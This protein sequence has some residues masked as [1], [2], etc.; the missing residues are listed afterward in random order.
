M[1]SPNHTR[2]NVTHNDSLDAYSTH[3]YMYILID[4]VYEMPTARVLEPPL[5]NKIL[6]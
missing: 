2:D 1:D 3:M 6:S 5:L 4:K